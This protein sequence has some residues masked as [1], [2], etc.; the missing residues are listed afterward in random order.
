MKIDPYEK[1]VLQMLAGIISPQPG[2]AMNQACEALCK[3]GFAEP[4]PYRITK[5]GLKQL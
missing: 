3:Q 2:A 5:K 4:N 1:K